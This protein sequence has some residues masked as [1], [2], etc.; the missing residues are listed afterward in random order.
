MHPAVAGHSGCG[1][2]TLLNLAG[3]ADLSRLRRRKIGFGFQFFHLLPTLTVMENVTLPLL[4][5]QSDIS[6]MLQERFRKL[7]AVV[8]LDRQA[9]KRLHRLL[10]SSRCAM[11]SSSMP[12]ADSIA[13]AFAGRQLRTDHTRVAV[14]AAS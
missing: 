8:G 13:I 9:G 1:K 7:L 2:S 3:A 6:A 4:L 12:N 11:A 14:D 10:G 5:G